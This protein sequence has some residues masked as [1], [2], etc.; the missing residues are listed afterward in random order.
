M[1]NLKRRIDLL[2]KLGQHLLGEDEYLRAVMHRAEFHNSWFTRESQ[3]LAIRSIATAFLQR[4]ALEALAARYPV[5]DEP[6]GKTVGVVMAGNIPLVGFHDWL[7]V[8]LAGH[9]A[10]VKLSEKD[11][12]LFPYLLK[13]MEKWEPAMQGWVETVER[14]KGFDMVIATGSNN[15]ARYFE[16][17]F[18]K[19][20]H[21]IRRN[22]NGV[23]VLSGNETQEELYELGKD[24]FTYF[25]LGCRNVAKIYV[26]E[27]YQFEPLLE[28]LHEYREIVLHEKYKHNFDYNYALFILNKVPHK[29]NG[30]ILLKEDDSLASRIACLHYAYYKSKEA[31]EREL[32]ERNEEVQCVAARPGYLSIPVIPFGGT[33]QPRLDEYADGVDTMA[34]LTT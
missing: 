30:C 20:P 16:A 10:Q 24:I 28:A 34:L 9:R 3:E 18:G 8:F 12:Y 31:V 1:M 13:L 2:V 4:E 14:L 17:Y 7:C 15:S 26:P 32:E 25:G 5:S 29:A 27:G 21:I 6:T 22:R 19:K 23:A 33:Q 11:A